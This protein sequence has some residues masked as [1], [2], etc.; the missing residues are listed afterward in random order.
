MKRLIAKFCL[1]FVLAAASASAQE[2]ER[3]VEVKHVVVDQQMHS[4]FSILGVQLSDRV[5]GYIALRGSKDSVA[6]AEEA[7]HR[8]DVEKP[9]VDVE[10][11]GWLVVVSS[12]SLPGWQALPSEL[13]PVAKQL[14]AAFGYTD[15]QVLTSFVV[16][17]REGSRTESSG[18]FSI[19][20][21]GGK[22]Y[23]YRF[24][25]GRVEVAGTTATRKLRL[26]G[27]DLD[28]REDATSVVGSFTSDIDLN[29]GQKAVIG[30]TSMAVAGGMPLFLVL[31]AH[32]APNE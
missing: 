22:N 26:N 17:A 20:G 21:P 9:E 6:A 29:E 19:P 8:M 5:G 30:K 1:S 10:L 27:F 2:V 11:T 24:L 31:T 15:L 16:R 4:L 28:I 7:L 32:V 12:Q 25:V 23:I 13:A 14:K 18:Q 3:L